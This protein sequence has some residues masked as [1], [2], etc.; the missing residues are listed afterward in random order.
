MSGL[1]VKNTWKTWALLIGRIGFAK[2]APSCFDIGETDNTFE[3][4]GVNQNHGRKNLNIAVLKL[5][6]CLLYLKLDFYI[7]Y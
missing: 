2:H 3:R 1:S 4:N 7:K 5:D 6:K